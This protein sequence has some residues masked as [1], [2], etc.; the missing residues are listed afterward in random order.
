MAR[1]EFLIVSA[2]TR[3]P[4]RYVSTNDIW[5]FASGD[6]RPLN[7]ERLKVVTFRVRRKLEPFG[8]FIEATINVGHRIIPRGRG[9]V[10][11]GRDP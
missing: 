10:R 1:V 4:C 8:I 7:G 9:T 3:K 5:K 2:L 6:S 11:V